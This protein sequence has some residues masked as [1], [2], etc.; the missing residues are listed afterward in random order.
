MINFCTSNPCKYSDLP[1]TAV[2]SVCFD[3]FTASCTGSVCTGVASPCSRVPNAIDPLG[4][5]VTPSWC[6]PTLGGYT[7][8]CAAGAMATPLC[9]TNES[10]SSVGVDECS[11]GPC[12]NGGVCTDYLNSYVCTCVGSFTDVNCDMDLGVYELV[13]GI[14][15]D[16]GLDVGV[17]IAG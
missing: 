7:C 15:S 11:S 5:S 9:D 14:G 8:H 10:A 3:C 2:C 1:T 12:M 13:E 17:E 16:L 4:A 6:E